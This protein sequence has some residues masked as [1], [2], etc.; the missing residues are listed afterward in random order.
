MKNV[1]LRIGRDG[2][3][4]AETH[5]LTG[6]ECLPYIAELERLLDAEAVDSEYTAEF[7]QAAEVGERATSIEPEELHGSQ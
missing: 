6:R 5:G 2:T 4:E 1:T 7:Y 3:V